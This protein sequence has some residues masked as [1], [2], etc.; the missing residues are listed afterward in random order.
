MPAPLSDMKVRI[1]YTLLRKKMKERR[2]KQC[3][4]SRAIPM[5]NVALWQ[6]INKGIPL[7]GRVVLRICDILNIRSGEVGEYFYTRDGKR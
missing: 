3:E 2:I 4:L 6:N 1:D 5:D 7:H